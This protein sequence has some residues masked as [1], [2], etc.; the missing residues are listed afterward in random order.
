MASG[1]ITQ[2]GFNQR[3]PA[4][5]TVLLQLDLSKAF[6][7]V[8]HNKLLKDLNTTTLPPEFKRWFGCYLHGRQSRVLFRN[9]TSTARNVRTGVLQGAVTSPILFNFYLAN[10]PPPPAG[11]A[12][13]QYADDM[14]VYSS[15]VKIP[16]MTARINS[17]VPSLLDFL[18]ER[19]LE[20]SAE[21]STVTLFTPASGEAGIHPQV[22]V[23]GKLVKLE[24]EPKLLGVVFDT[25]YTFGKHA[26]QTIAKG[27]SKIN[28][29]KQLAGTQW[30][31]DKETL[32][33]TY[34][35]IGRSTLEYAAPIWAPAIS[36]TH[37]QNLQNTQNH[38]LRTATGCLLMS[39]QDHLHQESMVMPIWQHSELLTKQFLA[40]SFLPNNPGHQHLNRQPPPRRMKETL[41]KYESEVANQYTLPATQDEYKKVLKSIHT[42]SVKKSIEDA[43]PNRVLQSLPPAI[44]P[45][46]QSLSRRA[47]TGLA[48]LRSGFSR[49]LKSYLHRMDETV[50]DQCP[51]CSASPHNT[52]HL[53]NCRNDETDLTVE[54]L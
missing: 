24:K 33:T 14:S 38:A 47:R 29:L 48:Q 16:D 17:Y 2:P 54:S 1:R 21:K 9:E 22:L 45:A 27:K 51:K 30:G 28:I 15:G 46:E 34:K 3:K 49:K 36:D 8:S 42:A 5:R 39:S 23:D 19:E 6:D 44:N 18:R 37:W 20:F 31:Q 50:T 43:A 25:M 41:L 4:H 53:F 13:M 12:V 52:A 35:A 40:G 26:K 7:M 32:I 11:V 10:L